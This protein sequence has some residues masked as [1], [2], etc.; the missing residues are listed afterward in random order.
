MRSRNAIIHLSEQ[1]RDRLVEILRNT[2]TSCN[3]ALTG[4]WDQS[5]DGFYALRAA[6]EE[7]LEILRDLVP[8]Y[9]AN[10]EPRNKGATT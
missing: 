7:G 3:D 10:S 6:A 9:D 4:A 2:A 5:E 1:D 8:E